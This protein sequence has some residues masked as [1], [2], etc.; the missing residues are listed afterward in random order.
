MKQ[1]TRGRAAELA[2]SGRFLDALQGGPR[3]LVL[4]GE[5]GI[6]KTTLWKQ[7]LA[8]ARARSYWV[9]SC[10]PTESETALSFAALAD[11][12]AEVP[13]EVLAG[14]PGPQQ[15]GLQVALL[16]AEP[17]EDA[18]DHRAISAG[19]LSV[20]TGLAT[21]APVVVGIDDLRWLDRPSARVLE[22]AVRRL[23]GLR[24]GLVATMRTPDEDVLPLGLGEA[25]P[26]DQ[27]DRVEVGPL[28]PMCCTASCGSRSGLPCP[29]RRWY[30]SSRP[31]GATHCSPSRSHGRS[32]EPEPG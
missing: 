9:L 16:R 21:R 5:A 17:A 11:L 7:V 30:A 19:L 32:T 26:A 10:R 29:G 20:L 22:F 3:G 14:L 23:A 2:V 18:R 1:S 31:R 6:G 13:V 15:R 8:E 12:L 24:V 25:L 28:A 4:A 27:L